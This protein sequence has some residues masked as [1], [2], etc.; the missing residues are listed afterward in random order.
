MA[1]TPPPT[2]PIEPT[3]LFVVSYYLNNDIATK[4]YL[5]NTT[6]KTYEAAVEEAKRFITE[7]GNAGVCTIQQVTAT[8]VYPSVPWVDF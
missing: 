5:A 4:P 3:T 7:G 8:I 1:T 6:L 2:W